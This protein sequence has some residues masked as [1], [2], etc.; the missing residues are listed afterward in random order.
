MDVKLGGGVAIKVKDSSI[1][2]HKRAR[3]WL[4]NTAKSNNIA[5]QLEVLISG[6]TDGGAMHTTK[7]G[8]ITGGVSI[9]ARYIHS[10][11]EC[12]HKKDIDSAT[13]LLIKA[14]GRDL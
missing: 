13:E 10:N 1:I 6:G 7:G 11:F 14:L 2:T 5:Y 4:I 8:V 12:A 3:D 9:P